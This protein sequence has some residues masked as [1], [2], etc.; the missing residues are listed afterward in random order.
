MMNRV[1]IYGRMGMDER[2]KKKIKRF[3]KK[4]IVR[5]NESVTNLQ[6]KNFPRFVELAIGAAIYAQAAA[7]FKVAVSQTNF[8]PYT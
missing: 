8:K 3:Q 6:S 4:L 5:T 2:K 7:T 1:T